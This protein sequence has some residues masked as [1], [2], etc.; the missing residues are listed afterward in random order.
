MR[1]LDGSTERWED[2]N[3]RRYFADILSGN[4]R[5]HDP[6]ELEDRLDAHVSLSGKPGQVCCDSV[7]KNPV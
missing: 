2:S 3:F 4:W 1:I 6:Y 7:L 5:Q